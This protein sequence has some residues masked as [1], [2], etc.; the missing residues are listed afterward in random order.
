MGKGSF[1]N[2]KLGDKR[3]TARLIQVAAAFAAG[4]CCDGGGTIT[5]VIALPHQAKAAYR[6]FDC[7]DVTHEAVLSGHVQWVH[8]QLT[9]PGVYLL[10]EDTTTAEFQGLKKAKG[11]GPIGESYTRGFWL[12]NTLALRLDEKLEQCEILGLAAQKA[13]AR[14]VERPKRRKSNGRGKESNYAR[15]R[16]ED[17]ES[18]RWAASLADLPARSPMVQYIYVA[19]RE[20]DIYEVFQRC[21]LYSVSSVIRASYPR[22]LAGE[23]EGSDL[24]TVV[25]LAKVLGTIDVEIA[26]E[27][28]TAKVEVRSATVELRGPARPGGRLKNLML[29]VVQ[30]R[31]V[32]P[33]P[34]CEAVCW[35]LLSDLPVETLEQ[36]T[37]IINIYRR[38]WLIEELHKAMKTGLKLEQSQLSDYRRL[39]ALAAVVSVAA[40]FLLDLKWKTRSVGDQ[41]LTRRE[42]ETPMVT[43]L[44][45]L[46]PPRQTPTQKWVGTS[47][48]KLGGFMGRKGDGPPGWLTL[49]R[50]WQTL[51]ILLRGYELRTG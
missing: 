44:E 27:N 4:S 19:D 22:A 6:L 7:T 33:P 42:R 16:R 8:E 47:I 10:I 23:F 34:G 14:P 32:N 21:Q 24:K 50:G 13:W 31:E 15:Q 49:W 2:V 39:S 29:N 40:V 36:C 25:R 18:M 43:I 35:I 46:H 45:R 28:R 17:R 26:R 3:R 37:R 30:A 48:A 38:R 51:L 41:P 5:S 9:D 12:H 1:G 20:S 11:L